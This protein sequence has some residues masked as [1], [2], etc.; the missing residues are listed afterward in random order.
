MLR[1]L[2]DGAETAEIA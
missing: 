2:A 1:L